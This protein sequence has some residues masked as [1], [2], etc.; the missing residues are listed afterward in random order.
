MNEYGYNLVFLQGAQCAMGS[1]TGE[2]ETKAVVDEVEAYL[3][4]NPDETPYRGAKIFGY[5][6]ARLVNEAADNAEK[7]EPMLNVAMSEVVVPVDKGLFHLAASSQ[8]LGFTVVNDRPLGKNFSFITEVGYIELGNDIV[9]LTAPGEIDPHLFYG[10][11][12]SAENSYLGTSW[13]YPCPAETLSDKTVLVVGL[14]NDA[15]GYI[16]PDGDCAPFIADSLWAMEIGD[17]KLGEA[18]YGPY[19]RHYEEL[20]TA[21]GK[22]GSSIMREINA[23]IDANR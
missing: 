22:A 2:V 6:F 5:E 19:H 16:L 3:R 7:V 10:N 18:L 17:W 14:C 12:V 13:D 20:L 11:V 21:G 15:I 4:E 23:L 1:R 8:L 9:I